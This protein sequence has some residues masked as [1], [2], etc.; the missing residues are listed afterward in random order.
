MDKKLEQIAEKMDNTSRLHCAEAVEF[1]KAYESSKFYKKKLKKKRNPTVEDAL[2]I[3]DI[4]KIYIAQYILDKGPELT[5]HERKEISLH[6]YNAYRFLKD[7]GVEGNIPEIL[8]IHSGEEQAREIFKEQEGDI[9]FPEIT[10]EIREEAK[11]VG[12]IDSF[13]GMIQRRTYRPPFTK[14][15]AVT[16]LKNRLDD[17]DDDEFVDGDVI[18]YIEDEIRKQKNQEY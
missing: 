16:N 17:D 9:P 8:L 15:A 7:E 2:A 10:D 18:S 3:M 11:T 4:G 5:E 1:Y 13:I 14:E 12:T 6:G